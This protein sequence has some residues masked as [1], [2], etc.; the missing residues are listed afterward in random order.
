MPNS[1]VWLVDDRQENREQFTDRHK[2]EFQVRTFA[3]PDQVMEAIKREPPPDALLCD[4]FYYEDADEREKVEAQVAKEAKRI[5]NLAAELHADQAADGIGLIERVRGQFSGDPPFPIYA[6]TSKGP[7]L[8]H[9]TEFDRLEQLGARWLFKNK[10]SPQVERS[11]IAK[12]I[13]HFR[14]RNQWT[15]RRMWGVAWRTGLI[16]AVAGAMLGVVFDRLARALGF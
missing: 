3:S 8:L 13:E 12:D 6:Y 4:I 11:R 15:A 1:K 7:Y 9:R 14:E 10:Y 16:A 2:S 5:E